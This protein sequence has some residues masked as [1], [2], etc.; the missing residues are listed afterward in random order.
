MFVLGNSKAGIHEH[1]LTQLTNYLDVSN[2]YRYGHKLIF[3]EHFIMY[4][5]L[6]HTYLT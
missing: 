2:R 5:A 6:S 1:D 4:K 3:A